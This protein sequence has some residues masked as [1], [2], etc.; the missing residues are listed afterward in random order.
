MPAVRIPNGGARLF[1]Q[2]SQRKRWLKTCVASPIKSLIW[3]IQQVRNKILEG[4]IYE[5][6]WIDGFH[7]F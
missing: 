1:N 3:S 2:D 4:I 7:F 6:G 5:G